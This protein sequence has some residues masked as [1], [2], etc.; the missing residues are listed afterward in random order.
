MRAI[1]KTDFDALESKA[2]CV[3]KNYYEDQ[4]LH[5]FTKQ[6]R[7]RLPLINIGTYCRV[8]ALDLC[9]QDFL[10]TNGPKRII[11][12]GCGSDTRPFHLLPQ[13]P[14][15]EI[16]ELDFE[17]AVAKKIKVINQHADLQAAIGEYTAQESKL[18][19]SRYTLVG[20]D[21]REFDFPQ[22]SI[23]TLVLAECC[24]CY[25]STSDANKLITKLT[26]HLQTWLLFY[27]PIGLND[28]FGRVMIENLEMRGLYMPTIAEYPT[29]ESQL[30]RLKTLGLI[31]LKYGD[32][33]TIRNNW[34]SNT[35]RER[36]SKLELLD[37]VEE[38]NL[39]LKHYVIIYS[40]K[41]E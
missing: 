20:C 38:M 17:V 26:S 28:E 2:S 35:E 7:P 41:V 34:F 31:P 4:Y 27:E 21:I 9:I 13:Y 33:E 23:P 24:L 19:S 37:E 16:L 39:L 36:L 3:Q 30:H 22:D 15:L 25:M 1:I 14:D 8:K 10:K 18:T 32:I 12:L 29:I 6:V 11:S 40:K 5:Y